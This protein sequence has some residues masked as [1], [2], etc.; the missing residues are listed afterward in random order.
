MDLSPEQQKRNQ[1][2]EVYSKALRAWYAAFK[3]VRL[4][5]PEHPSTK[6]SA[7]KI[8]TLLTEIFKMRFDFS[9]QHIDGLFVID[10][11]LFIEESLSFY[12]L[13]HSFEKI[14]LSKVSF[15]PG[16]GAEEIISLCSYFIRSEA[17]TN[18]PMPQAF[19]SEH[20]KTVIANPKD[21]QEDSQRTRARFARSAGVIDEW[22]SLLEKTFTKL[23]EEQNLL[24][25]DLSVPLEKL[26]EGVGQNPAD[27]SMLMVT[28]SNA[29]LPYQ[30]ALNSMIVS[31]FIG[32]QLNLDNMSMKTLAVAALL[33]DVGRLLLASDYSS[34]QQLTDADIDFI[35]LHARDGALFLAGVQGLPLSVIRAAYE[36]HVG[37]DGKGY[38]TLPE[39]QR[40]PL[41]SQII[42]LADFVSWATVSESH[43]HRP[44]A[45][46]RIVRSMIRRSGT[47]FSPLLVKLALPFFGLYPPGTVVELNTGERAIVM[48]PNVT[49]IA[50]PI[51]LVQ[52]ASDTPQARNLADS[53]ENADAPFPFSIKRILSHQR[54]LEVFIDH[55]PQ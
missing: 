37:F 7:Q 9:I 40:P 18:E 23:I 17:K 28:R 33:H 46:H 10:E 35:R 15:L 12:D 24:L 25:A 31:I 14:D 21:G 4:Y 22:H 5:S 49:H 52:G 43:Y 13:I 26:I 20:I 29:P 6:E 55:L 54:D 47:Q 51:V 3:N 34:G 44:K 45:P 11:M 41:M 38:P 53:T 27:F 16:V 48:Q 30:H 19:V 50:R 39:A 8:I 1:E 36:H 32:H 42:T 2:R